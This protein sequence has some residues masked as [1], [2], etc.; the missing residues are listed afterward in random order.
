[1]EKN[2][3]NEKKEDLISL[4]EA[5]KNE[6]GFHIF[7]VGKTENKLFVLHKKSGKYF[8]LQLNGNI[9]IPLFRRILDFL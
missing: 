4:L 5:A 3:R 6:A 2:R 1:M 9:S 7:N 8:K